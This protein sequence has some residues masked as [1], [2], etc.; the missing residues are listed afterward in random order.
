MNKTDFR[1]AYR[2]IRDALPDRQRKH[3]SEAIKRRLLEA[4][5]YK[6]AKVIMAYIAFGSEVET[7]DICNNAF[8]DGKRLAVPLCNRGNNTISA[9]EIKGQSELKEGCYGIKEP[10]TA[11]ATLMPPSEIDIVLVPALCYDLKGGRIGYGKG[12]YDRFLP[13]L[14][15]HTLKIGLAYEQQLVNSLPGEAHD[16]GLDMVI[17]PERIINTWKINS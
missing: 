6:N 2:N 3:L 11:I 9:W 4:D 5:F 17:T 13:L 1:K 7:N 15:S 8:V 12:Y 10:N 14:P 16:I